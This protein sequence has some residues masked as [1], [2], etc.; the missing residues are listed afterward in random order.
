M[1]GEDR[2]GQLEEIWA[3]TQISFV[4]G[5]IEGRDGTLTAAT[6]LGQLSK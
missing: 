3:T 2:G 6:M 4:G 5:G 1:S